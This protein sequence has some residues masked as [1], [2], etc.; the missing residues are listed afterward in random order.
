MSDRGEPGSAPD[1]PDRP[2]EPG[3][4]D[5]WSGAVDHPA[6]AGSTGRPP[7][8]FS[9]SNSPSSGAEQPG[10]GAGIPGL[11][12]LLAALGELVGGSGGTPDLEGMLK[13]VLGEGASL[14]PEVSQMLAALTADPSRNPMAAMVR[15]QLGTLFSNQSPKERLDTA[16]DIAR[17]MLSVRGDRAVT[18]AERR[19]V[20]DAVHVAQLWVDP[21]TGFGSAGGSGEAW[22]GADWVE[23]TMPTWY[24]LVEPVAEGVT[25]AATDALR[26]QFDQ[27]GAGALPEG[28]GDLVGQ[29]GPA[30]EQLSAGLF[31]AQIGQAVGT[32][33]ADVLGG[34]EVGLPLVPPGTVALLP[35]QV[36]QFGEGLGVDAT[37]VRLYLAVREVA[38]VRLFAEVPWLGSQLE[39]AVRDYGRHISIDTDAIESAV[40]SLDLGD[41]SA[42]QSAFSQ[43]QL[44]AQT[45]TPE[46]RAALSRLEATLA[47]VEGW[48]D[49]VTDQAVAQH[50]PQAEALG[51]AVRRRRAGGPAQKVFASLVGLELRP[52]RLKDAR[53]LWAALEQAGGVQL[54]DG[55]WRQPDLAPTAA[56]LDDPLGYTERR[57]SP[58]VRDA[59]D[60]E[61]DALLSGGSAEDSGDQD[62][63]DQ[64]SGDE[65]SGDEDSGEPGRPDQA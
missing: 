43:A 27:F 29:V 39:A 34:T 4:G 61:L 62:S 12:E 21:V 7:M 9:A 41:L 26:K 45:T 5:A 38:R 55:S 59:L 42:L 36:A 52:R 6:D 64:D 32:L 30:L 28:L 20:E 37:Q 31:A 49:L 3:S 46:Q 60:A 53:N 15:Q 1:D 24:N 19:E 18:D 14:P 25:R 44:F 40:R 11:D 58:P 33:A 13:S 51:E 16:R 57:T 23:A 8:G 35:A 17:K 56:D 47:L 22:S 48:V 54:R 65:D 50:L 2:E 10:S 63:G